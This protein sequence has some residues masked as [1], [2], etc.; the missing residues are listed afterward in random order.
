MARF[1]A[2]ERRLNA[3]I[4]KYRRLTHQWGVRDC[5]LFAAE[6]VHALTQK[7][8]AARWRRAY[9]DEAGALRIIAA[10]GGMA[11]LVEAGLAD[12]GLVCDRIERNFAQRG[13]LC[14]MESEGNPALGVCIGAEVVG[15]S[16]EGL[17]RRP[18]REAATVWAIR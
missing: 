10:H 18:L 4:D 11:G 14:L 2:W 6:C 5:A 8:P 3:A 17:A 1:E 12:A 7:D 15:M 13:D 9:S 16:P